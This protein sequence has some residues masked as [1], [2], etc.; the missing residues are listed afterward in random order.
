MSGAL[1]GSCR[2][3]MEQEMQCI[4]LLRLSHAHFWRPGRNELSLKHLDWLCG[5]GCSIEENWA[6]FARRMMNGS[7]GTKW[8]FTTQFIPFGS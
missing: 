5:T 8:I 7:W 4:H 3:T 2:I 6:T 1:M